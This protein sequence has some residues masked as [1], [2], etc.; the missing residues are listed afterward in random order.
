MN[1][2]TLFRVSASKLCT[3]VRDFSR[4]RA[5]VHRLSPIGRANVATRVTIRVS[6]SMLLTLRWASAKVGC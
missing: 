1:E 3:G 4:S 2:D 5:R 6:V